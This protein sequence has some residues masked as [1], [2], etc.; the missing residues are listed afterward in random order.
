MVSFPPCKI[1]LGLHVLRRRNDG[2]HDI[3]S[4]FYPVPW[5]DILEI[6]P[7]DSFSFTQSGIAVPGDAKNNLCVRAYERLRL[8][9][10]IG[11]VQMHLHK[12]IP[13]GA[14]LG[15]GSSDG[16]HTLRVLNR[17]FQLKLNE[18]QL[19]EHAS[20]LGSDCS[21][22]IFDQPMLGQGRGEVL[23]PLPLLLRGYYLVVVKPDVHVSTA[24]AYRAITPRSDRTAL[25]TMLKAPISDWKDFLENDFEKSVFAQFPVIRKLKE[26]MYSLGAVYASM[27]GSGS[28]VY[29][30]FEN[31][32]DHELAFTTHQGWSG[33]L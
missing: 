24:E 15:G 28:S 23:S 5:T 29:G 20:A 10:Q 8:A 27:S 9:H 2:Y 25:E 13:M 3:D 32:V 30:L 7:S 14:G 18:K 22:F 31:K 4:V 16:A 12:I 11:P 33:W 17:V 6:L 21:F 1:N 26:L 19:R